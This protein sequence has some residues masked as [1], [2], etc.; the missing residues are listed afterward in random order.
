MADT[1]GKNDL[2]D[3]E[4]TDSLRSENENKSSVQPLIQKM[5][6]SNADDS[7]VVDFSD[8]KSVNDFIKYLQGLT[9]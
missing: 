6:E 7:V 3:V 4:D 2:C 8:S 1:T 9:S 5:P